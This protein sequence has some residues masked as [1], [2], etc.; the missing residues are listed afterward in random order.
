MKIRKPQIDYR[1]RD[2]QFLR[3]GQPV[4]EDVAWNHWQLCN[5]DW[6]ET[7]YRELARRALGGAT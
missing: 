2:K 4:S 3:D 7:A 5:A 6:S 1:A